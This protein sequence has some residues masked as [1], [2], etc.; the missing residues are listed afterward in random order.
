MVFMGLGG[1]G[2]PGLQQVLGHFRWLLTLLEI[3][4]LMP[5]LYFLSWSS[6]SLPGGLINC[7]NSGSICSAGYD[8]PLWGP[9]QGM[10]MSSVGSCMF[11]LDPIW[12]LLQLVDFN[13]QAHGV[14]K[15]LILTEIP[16]GAHKGGSSGS[17]MADVQLA[18][19]SPLLSL[20]QHWGVRDLEEKLICSCTEQEK[21]SLNSFIFKTS[22]S[23]YNVCIYFDKTFA[24]LF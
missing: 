10:E 19:R 17:G 2:R 7:I 16:G 13:I 14:F 3:R 6:A 24:G 5:L 11:A 22:L 1:H 23:Q 18:L 20:W 9:L 8:E 12:M 15:Y 21:P 4:A